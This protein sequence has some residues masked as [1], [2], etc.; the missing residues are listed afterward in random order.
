MFINVRALII[1]LVLFNYLTSYGYGKEFRL[2]SIDNFEQH[3]GLKFTNSNGIHKLNL[4]K[5]YLNSSKS[6][7][8]TNVVH[9]FSTN[10]DTSKA[11]KIQY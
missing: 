10:P 4:K 7:P 9:F 5:Y 6:V 11:Y 2:L 8:P 1:T 3:E